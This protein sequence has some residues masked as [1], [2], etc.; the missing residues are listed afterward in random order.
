MSSVC[1]KSKIKVNLRKEA[2]NLTILR[3][4]ISPSQFSRIVQIKHQKIIFLKSHR[5]ELLYHEQEISLKKIGG[6]D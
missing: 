5:W 4:K 1:S 2:D 6:G 3:T